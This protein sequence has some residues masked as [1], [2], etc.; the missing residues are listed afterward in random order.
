MEPA[1]GQPRNNEDIKSQQRRS[2]DKSQVR[3]IEPQ[4]KAK[5]G[6]VNAVSTVASGQD[7]KQN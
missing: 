4:D 1:A 3:L 6:K 2:L 7:L 5:A